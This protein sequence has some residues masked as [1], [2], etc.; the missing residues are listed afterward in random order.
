[1][2]GPSRRPASLS[3]SGCMSSPRRWV[4]GRAARANLGWRTR[5]LAEPGPAETPRSGTGRSKAALAPVAGRWLGTHLPTRVGRTERE[6]GHTQAPANANPIATTYHPAP[7]A[8]PY[9]ARRQH[10]TSHH[11]TEAY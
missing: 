5:A 2:P 11:G 10:V 4:Y 1:M 7:R 6:H 9:A 3:R 8:Q